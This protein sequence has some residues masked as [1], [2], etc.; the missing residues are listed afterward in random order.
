[1]SSTLY[2]KTLSDGTPLGDEIKFL[3]RK[4]FGEPIDAILSGE[5]DMGWLHGAHACAEEL[6]QRELVVKISELI[7]TL[8]NHGNLKIREVQVR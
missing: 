6:G 4:R 5:K 8:I 2:W 3:L 1:M 7:N